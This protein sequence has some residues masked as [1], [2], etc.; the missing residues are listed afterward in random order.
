MTAQLSSRVAVAS[1]VATTP[2]VSTTPTVATTPAVATT[3]PGSSGASLSGASTAVRSPRPIPATRA[4]QPRLLVVNPAADLYG[5]DRMLLEAAAGAV[6]RGWH[7]AAALGGDGPLAEALTQAAVH[8]HR[9]EVPVLRKSDLSPAGLLRLT[10]GTPAALADMG[11]FVEAMRPDVVYVNTVTMPWWL[12]VARRLR[13]RSVIH[14]HEAEAGLPAHLQAALTAPLRLADTVVFNSRT[15][16]AVAAAVRGVGAGLTDAPV[17]L[18]GLSARAATPPRE[19][20]E[21]GVRLLYVG[22][23]SQRKG[24]DVAVEAMRL[25]RDRGVAAHLEIVG[26]VFP[27]YEAF[28]AGLRAAIASAGLEST[29]TLHG[30]CDDVTDL[31]AATDIAL[32]PSIADESF[33]N[34]VIESLLAQRP[35]VVADQAGLSE[36]GEGFASVVGT[37]AGDAAALADAVT[38]IATDWSRRRA[39]VVR[40]AAAAAERHAPSR[41]RDEIV[42]VLA[43][44]P[45]RASR[46]ALR[47]R[48]RAGA[49]P[50]ESVSI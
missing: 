20:L 36:A 38:A 25:L 47:R 32:V 37:R 17:V 4:R 49:I 12:L 42:A 23:L 22:R 11:A 1:T 40:D 6:E 9:I 39:W 8:V 48:A 31:R 41:Y 3:L 26:A 45:A 7:V 19:R 44:A 28:E 27:G 34:V 10:I 15:S 21:G 16:R 18:N 43:A 30:F 14:V 33:G 24:V 5:S 46:R 13:V 29:V 50:Q 2:A 35:V